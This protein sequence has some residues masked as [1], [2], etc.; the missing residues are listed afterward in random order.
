MTPVRFAIVG[1]GRI[2]NF[3]AEPITDLLDA[4]WSGA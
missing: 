4:E 3:H 2:A 1:C